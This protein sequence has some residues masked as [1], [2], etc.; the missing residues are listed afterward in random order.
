MKR[1]T[2]LRDRFI[3][4]MVHGERER[5]AIPI[6][7]WPALERA[8]RRTLDAEGAGEELGHLIRLAI[9]LETELESPG[10]AASIR[11]MLRGEPRALLVIRRTFV[12]ES[13]LDEARRFLRSEGR[14]VDFGAPKIAHA[15]R[16]IE[17]PRDGRVRRGVIG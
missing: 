7:A 13:G 5:Y 11:S 14:A 6:W 17:S 12:D 4:V 16:P 1:T 2:K 8:L 15:P 3:S 10:A 9:A